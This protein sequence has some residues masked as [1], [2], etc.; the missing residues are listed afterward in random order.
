MSKRT[1][2]FF[3]AGCA[4]CDEALHAVRAASCEGCDLRILDI[5]DPAVAARAKQLGVQRVPAVAI[6][7][8]IAAC[9]AAATVD[10][11]AL[12]SLGLGAA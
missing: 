3:S 8:R 11:D 5:R 6:D 2:E 12:R 7:G 10:V 4:C 1:I 9:C